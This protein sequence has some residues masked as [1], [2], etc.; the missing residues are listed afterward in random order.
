MTITLYL[1]SR[2]DIRDKLVDFVETYSDLN[3][4]FAETDVTKGSLLTIYTDLDVN[5][6]ALELRI[7]IGKLHSITRSSRRKSPLRLTLFAI[8]YSET[9]PSEKTGRKFESE[10]KFTDGRKRK[11]GYLESR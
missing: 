5:H 7:P 10:Q 8:Q 6:L 4:H 2:D 11:T 9:E 1:V 3:G